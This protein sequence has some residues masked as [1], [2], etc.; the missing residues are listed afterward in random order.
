MFFD[1][2]LIKKLVKD[3]RLVWHQK[4]CNKVVSKCI[5]LKNTFNVG[6]IDKDKKS[7]SQLISFE[8]YS[9]K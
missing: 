7:I 5:N 4:G 9:V 8:N 3:N 1:T 6:I 2:I